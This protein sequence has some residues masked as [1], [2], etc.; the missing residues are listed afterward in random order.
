M[1]LRVTTLTENSTTKSGTLAEH[2]LSM[3][4]EVDDLL[5]LLDTGQT[6]TAVHNAR[7]LGVDLSR[8]HH[9]V[10]SH[11]HQDHTGGLRSVLARMDGAWVYAHTEVWSPRY[12][13]QDGERHRYN[14]VPFVREQLESL[15]A[16]F[17]LSDAPV[18]IAPGLITTGYVPRRNDFERLDANQ[19][20]RTP[21]GWKQDEIPDD[22]ALLV[23]TPKGLVVL[24]GCAHSGIVNT[25]NRAREVAQEEGVFAVLGGT[26]LK[27][28]GPEQMERT[29]EALRQ[30]DIRH[31]GVS[32]CTGL[33][34][35]ARLAQEFGERFFFN[36]VGTITEWEF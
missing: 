1:R 11:G 29:V 17:E 32:H 3:L 22:Q 8:V 26:H 16:A 4:L 36:N 33:P 5:V 6:D 25:L 23:K 31:I 21:L 20:V 15:G 27:A 28:A 35:A 12:G 9:I 19:K 30:M 24:L 7:L 18:A 34:A 2:G 10:L 13:V 14:G